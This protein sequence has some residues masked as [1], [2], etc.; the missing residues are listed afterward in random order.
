MSNFGIITAFTLNAITPSNPKG[1]WTCA[2]VFDSSK[3]PSI[4]DGNYDLL[5]SHVNT[6]PDIAY[7][8]AAAYDVKHDAKMY[9]MYQFHAS[10]TN[11]TTHP[12]KLAYTSSIETLMPPSISI[13]SYSNVTKMLY[14]TNPPPGKRNL[15][16][17]FSYTPSHELD[18][19]LTTYFYD[20]L[21]P[22]VK[23]I[24]GIIPT[25]V[26][27]PTFSSQ[28]R[29][30]RGGNALGLAQNEPKAMNLALLPW[31]WDNAS[32]DEFMYATI[33][34]AVEQGEA[35]AKEL[36]VYHPFVYA[37]Y[38]GPWQD[39]WGGYG[40]EN[41]KGLRELQRRY[42]PAEV[43]VKGGLCGGGFKLNEKRE[44]GGKVKVG[45]GEVKDEL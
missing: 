10:E 18:E 45:K 7:I 12:E 4:L 25:I 15:Y 37:N 43:F 22:K 39:V 13:M 30:I 21:V 29:S 26:M 14:S 32:D 33:R 3:T 36:G 19:K 44:D 11:I 42:D 2:K 35:W 34:A 9:V 6:D 16:V 5:S 17:S 8:H 1:F 31:T 38:A 23:H 41:V 20:T 27:Q 28:Q 40:E 24:S